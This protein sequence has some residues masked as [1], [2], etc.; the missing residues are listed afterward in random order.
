[1]ED[2]IGY[3]HSVETGGIVDGP[4]LRYVVFTTGCP[5]RCLYCHN[6]DTM[7]M[8]SGTETS[9]YALLKDIATY[10]DYFKAG[11]GG[12]TISGG[13]PMAQKEFLKV[14]MW[15]ARQMGVHVTVDTSGYMHKN[16]DDETLK[17]AD[18]YLL[19]IKS[20]LPQ[21]YKKVTGVE[22]EPTLQFAKRLEALGID[23]WIRFVLVPDLTDDL[24][25]IEGVAKFCSELSNVKR[26]DVLPF[27]K[28]G[29]HK[30]QEMGKKYE[31]SETRQP[32]LEETEA[33]RDIFRKYGLKTY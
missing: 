21:T 3:V 13:E 24:E 6:P 9:A 30:W 14:L 18:L 32:E 5:L 19:D 26:V 31:L 12:L 10:R 2:V 33:A 16:L 17:L 25:N 8:K 11:G 20:F 22:I 29:E 15:G 7:K 28:M 23:V 1:M 4:G 27:H